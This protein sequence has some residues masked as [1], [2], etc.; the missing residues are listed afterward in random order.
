[1]S[2]CLC[3]STLS[4]TCKSTI[5]IHQ[6]TPGPEGKWLGVLQS[7]THLLPLLVP[8]QLPLLEL[9]RCHLLHWHS[10]HTL[11]GCARASQ[12]LVSLPE[13]G[14]TVIIKPC[15]QNS[16]K[17]TLVM[18][19]SLCIMS[20]LWANAVGRDLHVVACCSSMLSHGSHVS[21]QSTLV[22]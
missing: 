21:N 5:D 7:I 3:R 19:K 1:M 11:P 6:Q 16:Q 13:S 9:V 10:W 4:L 20:A 8:P 17:I 15:C 14:I 12:Q 2:A 18:H 22:P